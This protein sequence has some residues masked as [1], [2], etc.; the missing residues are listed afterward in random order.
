MRCEMRKIKFRMWD[1]NTKKFK[2]CI[3]HFTFDIKIS[4]ESIEEGLVSQYTGLKDKNDKE[5]YE[6]DIVS[7]IENGLSEVEYWVTQGITHPFE[8]ID[9][10]K[11][12]IVGNIYEPNKET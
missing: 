9:V 6:G 12:E 4:L 1:L 5:I 2:E 8:E 7:S 10:K 3:D 11:C